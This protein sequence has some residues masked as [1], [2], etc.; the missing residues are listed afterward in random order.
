MTDT[1][2]LDWLEK[3]QNGLALVHDDNQHWAVAFCGAQNVIMGDEPGD[4]RTSY[5]VEKGKFRRT[6]REAI[7]A[8]V[9][10]L[11]AESE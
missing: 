7:D 2:R 11:E 5:S 6:I 10:E 3:E 4:L 1:E 8:A 9:A